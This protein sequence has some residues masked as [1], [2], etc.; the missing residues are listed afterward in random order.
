MKFQTTLYSL[1]KRGDQVIIEQGELV[2]TAASGVPVPPEWMARNRQELI[3]EVLKLLDVPDIYV[4]KYYT[5]GKYGQH[6]AEGIAL[7]FKS[8]LTGS[9]FYGIFNVSL[10]RARNTKSGKKGKPLPS[11]QFLPPKDGNFCKLWAS[12]ELKV[13]RRNS[14]YKEHINKMKTLHFVATP[15]GA[16][17]NRL[18]SATIQ[19]IDTSLEAITKAF[20]CSAIMFGKQTLKAL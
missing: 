19:S 7:Q 13:P 11:G 10:K 3:E 9:S 17:N 12:T 15:H 4:Y 1:I 14:E 5:V 20:Y 18:Q 2:V 16:V 8:I 6:N